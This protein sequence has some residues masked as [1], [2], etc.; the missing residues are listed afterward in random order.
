MHLKSINLRGFKTFADKTTLLFEPAPSIT[1]IVGPN[2]CGKS[3]VIDSLRFVIGE[4]SIKELRG[5]S[6]E[7]VIF[8][9]TS[10][11]K[12]LSMAEVSLVIDNSDFRLKADYS[13]IQIKRRVFRS[14]ESE[15]YINKNLCRLK[16]IKELFLD[17]GIGDGAYSIVNQGQVDSILSSKP[18]ERRA[19]F[20]EAAAIGKYKF[21]KKAA[22]RRL[23]ATEQNLLRVNDIR[24]EIKENLSLLENQAAKAREYK[25]LKSGLKDIE[26]GLGK[27]QVGS[28]T[29]KRTAVLQRIEELKNRTQGAEQGVLQEE[30]ERS[31]IKE[32][33]KNIEDSIEEARQRIAA[34]KAG[35]ES[36]KSSINVGNERVSQLGER[37]EQLKAEKEKL[38]S[39]LQARTEKLREKTFLLEEFKSK[40]GEAQQY[41]DEAKKTFDELNSRIEES[42][43][44]WDSLKNPIFEREMEMSSKKH[45]LAEI[46]LTLKYAHEALLKEKAFYDNLTGLKEDISVLEN[47][48]FVLEGVSQELKDRIR[49]RKE[50]I[51]QKIDIETGL[52]EKNMEARRA[53]ISSIEKLRDEEKGKLE[54]AQSTAGE[55]TEQFKAL[56]G[57]M[58][59]L[60]S[61]KEK[62]IA[63]LAETRA[64]HA[65][66]DSLYRQKQEEEKNAE[67]S[68]AQ[69]REEIKSKEQES[70]A[71]AARVDAAK[72]EIARLE[73]DLPKMADS[74]NALAAS[75]QEMIEKRSK[76][77]GRLEALEEKIRSLSSEDRGI[78]DALYKEEI[79]LARIDGELGSIEA[80]MQQEYQMTVEQML[81]SDAEEPSNAAKAKEDI[82]RLRG[83]IRDIGPVNLLAVEEFEAAKER[84]S[85]IETQYMDLVNARDNLNS[86]VRDLDAEAKQRFLKTIEEVNKHFTE[87]FAMLFEGG[88]AQIS[89]EEGD[90]LEA[91]IEIKAKPLGKKW[92]SLTLMS[93][94]E[95][96]LTAIAILFA[97]MKVNPSPF[98]FL[99][100]VDAALDEINTI[101][102]TK[103][104][105]E[106][107]KH[108]QIVVITHSKRTMSAANEM[109]GV[110]ME[111]P[112]I[113]KLVSMKLVKV[114]D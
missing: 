112:G 41:L 6:L 87:I 28:L 101:R 91:G 109:Y 54:S 56:E 39:L 43:K 84:L 55:M 40:Y 10:A 13:E 108:S 61:E 34:L 100:E 78:R 66:F 106:F 111:E 97:L 49:Q 18:E 51:Y 114:A 107:G 86:L 57:K 26:I 14:G 105:K 82:E 30:E 93:G 42:I 65:G 22:E 73:A 8:A 72:A 25:E 59:Q 11:K 98:C 19:V 36:A 79:A 53:E 20:E 60:T 45:S 5:T 38:A 70:V 81:R 99:D 63:R 75:L 67:E 80:L 96:A 71:L 12:P 37:I 31:R 92:L 7:E 44:G 9:G 104:L 89:L 27:K 32:R 58:K 94:G 21:R 47:E 15:F 113:S 3:N 83:A 29:E 33:V 74:E 52:I 17:T 48:V 4:Q 103:L 24:S 77:Q 64:T 76:E 23:I 102:F 95:K 90:A 68:L 2:G 69:A 110:T 50:S 35:H 16:D 88:E 62:A 46:E 85:F 1:A